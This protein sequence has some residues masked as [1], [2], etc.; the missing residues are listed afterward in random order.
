MPTF[1][2]ENPILKKINANG[3]TPFE[4]LWGVDKTQRYASATLM[5]AV[6]NKN[7]N[8][9]ENE[10]KMES[11]NEDIKSSTISIDETII[12][13]I[14]ETDNPK[15]SD[16]MY[17]IENYFPSKKEDSHKT[18]ATYQ[19]FWKAVA[20]G[21]L[22]LED[23]F[24]ILYHAH[25]NTV[26]RLNIGK[27]C[28]E[29]LRAKQLNPVFLKTVIAALKTTQKFKDEIKTQDRYE[30]GR[31]P[32][33]M[34]QLVNT[35]ETYLSHD[36]GVLANIDGFL[37]NEYINPATE[38]IKKF[39]DSEGLLREPGKPENQALLSNR[40]KLSEYFNQAVIDPKIKN[41]DMNAYKNNGNVNKL[42]DNLDGIAHN[43]FS[44]AMHMAVTI[45]GAVGAELKNFVQ[46]R[47][48]TILNIFINGDKK[49][50]KEVAKI[51]ANYYFIASTENL[52]KPGKTLVLMK[53]ETI[54]DDN[55]K[56]LLDL[57][58]FNK[59]DDFLKEFFSKYSKLQIKN[60]F[61]EKE[62][63]YFIFTGKV[64]TGKNQ[65]MKE[66]VAKLINHE[67]FEKLVEIDE[68]EK[69][70]I[71]GVI[72][73]EGKLEKVTHAAIQYGNKIFPNLV[74]G[75]LADFFNLKVMGDAVIQ[76]L[77]ADFKIM[78][79]EKWGKD[80]AKLPPYLDVYAENAANIFASMLYS[81]FVIPMMKIA[82]FLPEKLDEYYPRTKPEQAGAIVQLNQDSISYNFISWFFLDKHIYGNLDLQKYFFGSEFIF[83]DNQES[84]HTPK[85]IEIEPAK[86]NYKAL[87]EKYYEM[88][89]VAKKS[90]NVMS[91][92]DFFKFSIAMLL[93]SGYPIDVVLNDIKN[94]NIKVEAILT[95]PIRND[96][97]DGK[98]EFNIL[99]L[100]YLMQDEVFFKNFTK[101]FNSIKISRDTIILHVSKVKNLTDQDS[102]FYT[103][104]FPKHIGKFDAKLNKNAVSR[105]NSNEEQNFSTSNEEEKGE[106]TFQ[107]TEILYGSNNTSPSHKC[108]LV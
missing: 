54:T 43:Y 39:M 61:K 52:D 92:E 99:Q 49:A 5:T 107:Q 64:R 26:F 108:T 48:Q 9:N 27:Q 71:E 30:F 67:G 85:K 35:L 4:T 29:I 89:K 70:Q 34:T 55:G 84:G 22:T 88:L 59:K 78:I 41:I 77:Q 79:I 50:G 56:T 66:I 31:N 97:T 63:Y 86:I 38:A 58:Q 17:F 1:D 94:S 100:A 53:I 90:K 13:R 45:P 83:F 75:L 15:Y 44:F 62:S 51:G 95:Q 24:A 37:K 23:A 7:E 47:M 19:A 33:A 81:I 42:I 98:T 96:L 93:L 32:G 102:D 3:I 105:T 91:N 8:K 74:F 18:S 16:Y 103:K 36:P 82:S 25:E 40:L 87:A 14:I 69:K 80:I 60:I 10:N 72:K 21:A 12:A 6:V 101:F 65:E 104:W 68:N 11:N 73:E 57:V 46:E 2:Q 76:Q 28:G 20:D 106:N